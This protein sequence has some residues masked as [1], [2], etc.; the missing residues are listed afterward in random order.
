MSAEGVISYEKLL[1]NGRNIDNGQSLSSDEAK[2]ILLEALNKGRLWVERTNLNYQEL[3][4]IADDIMVTNF[5]CYEKVVDDIENQNFDK[6]EMQKATL[7]RHF[8]L[9]E[10]QYYET[11][12][13]Y[14]DSHNE[15][16]LPALEGK[17]TILKQKI[18]DKLLKIEKNKK[19]EPEKNDICM[20]L[21]KAV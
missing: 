3:S 15:R 13:K 2:K 11:R 18:D 4:Q 12:Q 9:K 14:I 16:M 6:A 17:F 21:V 7:Q 1:F 8:K 19:I 5:L 10:A 20:V